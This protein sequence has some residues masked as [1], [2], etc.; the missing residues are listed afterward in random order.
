[1]RGAL[2]EPFEFG[3][4]V[5]NRIE[6]GA[7]RR[8]VQQRGAGSFNG[9]AHADALVAGE[10]VHDHDVA[11]GERRNQLLPD[12]GEKDFAVDGFCDGF[13]KPCPYLAGRSMSS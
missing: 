10:V 12:V 4:G 3:G 6:V 1:M 2:E 5:F 11:V 9:L 13:L 8:Q 7:L